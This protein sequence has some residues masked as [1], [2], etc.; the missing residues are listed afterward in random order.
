MAKSVKLSTAADLMDLA[1]FV[2]LM[3][4]NGR[5][6]RLRIRSRSRCRELVLAS[7]AIVGFTDPG[8]PGAVEDAPLEHVVIDGFVEVL[9]WP[10]PELEFTELTPEEIAAHVGEGAPA[11]LSVQGALLEVHQTRD[12]IA[13]TSEVIR[14][15]DTILV[16][17][18]DAR[19]SYA[20]SP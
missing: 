9:D 16:V 3:A 13:R 17:A 14:S 20:G 18:P 15:L 7:G 6:G 11:P 8:D 4:M 2:Q 10:N 5:T 12:L 1:D 19:E